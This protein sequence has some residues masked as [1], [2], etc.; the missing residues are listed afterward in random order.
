MSEQ[1]LYPVPSDFAAKAHIDAA[2]YQAMYQRSIDDPEG[3][4]AEQAEQ[5]LSWYKP[6]DKVLD[7]SFEGNVT[8]SGSRAASSMS[9]TTASTATWNPAATRWPSSGKGTIPPST[10]RSPTASCTRRWPNSA[11]C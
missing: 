2:T 3:F 8:L 6:W 1:K 4:W 11:T 5:F 7:W 10:K 9:P